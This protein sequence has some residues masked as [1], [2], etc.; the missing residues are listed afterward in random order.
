M[1]NISQRQAVATVL[2]FLFL[3]RFF[4]FNRPCDSLQPHLCHRGVC[5]SVQKR[6]DTVPRASSLC[7]VQGTSHKRIQNVSTE[8]WSF[9]SSAVLILKRVRWL[10]CFSFLLFLLDTVLQATSTTT[11]PFT[12]HCVWCVLVGQCHFDCHWC[13]IKRESFCCYFL[14]YAFSFGSW[15]QSCIVIMNMMILILN[16]E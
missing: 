14:P 2:L 3:R 12:S 6:A 7:R 16:L 13:L 10:Y 15:W 4:F 1:H 8:M 5:F 11:P 9:V